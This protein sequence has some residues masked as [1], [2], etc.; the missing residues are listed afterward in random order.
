MFVL[1]YECQKITLWE[2]FNW[3]NEEKKNN[4]TSE[5]IVLQNVYLAS[6]AK[7]KENYTTSEHRTARS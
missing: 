1:T 4:V 5:F 7:K 6:L 3:K 2:L